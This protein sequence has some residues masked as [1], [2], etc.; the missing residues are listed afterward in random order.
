MHLLKLIDMNNNQLEDDLQRLNAEME[1][2]S[3]EETQAMLDLC[4]RIE[5]EMDH[6][7]PSYP[8]VNKRIKEVRELGYW[9]L[10]R[11]WKF[12][13]QVI[14][15]VIVGLFLLHLWTDKKHS[16]VE[17]NEKQIE[18]INS[19]AWESDAAVSF[20]AMLK[21]G[22]KDYYDQNTAG[23][24]R[25]SLMADQ[26]RRYKHSVEV[27]KECQAK[28]DTASTKESKKQNEEC[29]E[30]CRQRMEECVTEG[31]RISTMSVEDLRKEHLK[32]YTSQR[33]KGQNAAS[34]MRFWYIFFLILTPI[35]I[36]ACRPFGYLIN[37]HKREGER[38]E[39]IRRIGWWLAGLLAGVGASIG[40]VNI[41][42]TYSDGSKTKS[43]DGTG[44]VRLIF[45]GGLFLAAAIVFAFTS[46]FIMVYSTIS[47]LIRNYNWKDLLA[48]KKNENQQIA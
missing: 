22:V 3:R 20:D 48:S 1:P 37:K 25:K 15:G 29:V 38:V 46:M 30:Q 24:Y 47:G 11:H 16:D 21:E 43:D 7:A 39:G 18:L 34:R 23:E 6:S 44:P 33:D 28:A 36:F 32:F 26:V 27:M 40:F 5:A 41:I 10:K 9:A 19:E 13:W 17:R 4:D 35:Y 12:S 8:E 42:T 14:L 45:K 2:T 31:K